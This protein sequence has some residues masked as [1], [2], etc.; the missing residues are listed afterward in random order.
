MTWLQGDEAG[1]H[2]PLQLVGEADAR[3]LP[4]R[5]MLVDDGLH[6]GGAQPFSC[7]LDYVVRPPMEEPVS[8]LVHGGPVPVEPDTGPPG[9][10]GLDIPLRLVPEA[11]GH[12]GRRLLADQI[13]HLVPDRLAVVVEDI[14]GHPE[15]GAPKRGGLQGHDREGKE[16]AAE[17]LRAPGEV[18]EGAP[19]LPDDLHQPG[20]GVGVDGLPGVPS[21][22]EAAQVV[23]LYPF[24][25]EALQ[26]PVGGGG[27]PE[28]GDPELLHH[29]PDPVRLGVVDG[30]LEDDVGA[31]E[32]LG[33]YDLPGPH[34][35]ADVRDPYE[36]VPRLQVHVEVD[37]LGALEEGSGVGDDRPLR[38]PRRPRGIQE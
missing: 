5:L 23:G 18:D 11:P 17:D 33:S 14:D 24:V 34:H 38:P 4:H 25:P 19:A 6:L 2:L 3:G 9:P 12:G 37:L 7:D 27:A 20:P 35:P 30:A 10:V 26:H 29:G 31:S 32:V 1:Q 15:A 13:T 22:P 28:V 36:D 21:H 16:E 8:V